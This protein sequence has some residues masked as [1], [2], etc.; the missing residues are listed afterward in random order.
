MKIKYVSAVWC[1]SCIVMYPVIEKLKELYKDIEFEELDYDTIDT[2]KYDITNTLP[3]LII[4]N[5]SEEVRVIGE[6][7]EKEIIKILEEIRNK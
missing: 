5:A 1:M 3:V 6:K 7:K 4:Q 2:K